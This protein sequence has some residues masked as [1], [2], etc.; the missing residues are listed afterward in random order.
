MEVCAV[1]DQDTAGAFGVL[2]W[3]L[4][5]KR[6]SS[7][8]NESKEPGRGKDLNRDNCGMSGNWCNKFSKKRT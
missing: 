6:N 1:E 8:W 3:A 5:N 4:W 7:I 2:M